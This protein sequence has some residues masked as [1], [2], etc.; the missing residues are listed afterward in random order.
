MALIMRNSKRFIHL[1]LISSCILLLMLRAAIAQVPITQTPVENDGREI[2]VKYCAAC[3]DRPEETKAPALEALQEMSARIITYALTEGKMQVH[4]TSM[5]AEEV[6]G[7]VGYL[8]AAKEVD[9]SWIAANSCP[10]GRLAADTGLPATVNG[11]GLGLRN[12]RRM[13]A[14]QAGLKKNDMAGLQLE[15]A[16]G[17]PQTASM[18]SQPV[19]IG[20]TMYQLVADNGQ[21]YALDI[22]GQPCVKW[23]YEHIVPLRTTIHAGKLKDGR[24]ALVFGDV[25]AHVQMLD[26]E[27]GDLIWRTSVR[28]SSVSNTTGMPVF[29][30]GRI[31]A[32]VSSGE[33]NMGAAPEYECCTSHGGVVA[34]D[35]ENGEVIWTYHTMGEPK[36]RGVNRIGTQLWGPSGAPIWTTPAI[37]EKRGVLYVGT[38]QNTS[39]PPT[40]TSD[41]VLAI[42]LED[43]SLRWKFQATQN[44]IFLT[45]CFFQPGGP[46]CP[47]DYSI[48]ADWD[49]GASM[50][51]AERADGSD[52]ILAG[53]K[54][55]E[56]WALDPDRN[57]ALLWHTDVGPGGIAGGI[58]WGMAYDG[59]RVFAAVNQVGVKG[60]DPDREPGLHAIDVNNGEILWS[61]LNHADCSGD[62][63]QRINSCDRNYGLSAAT[64][65][66][67][68]AV[69]QGGND[70]YVRIF[71]GD[72]GSMLFSYDTA[73][74]FQTLNGV[75]GHGGS[76]DC[77][78]TIAA[79]G[80]LFV[81]SGYGAGGAPGNVLLA[82]KPVQ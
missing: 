65:L 74:E 79:N 52:I 25:A 71:D 51:I 80:M 28:I 35:A 21:V 38:G 18:R 45:G 3:H 11:F 6:D 7:V 77:M 58:H 62:R 68:G 73:K 49:F 64:L 48:N 37:D 41:A 44:D 69:I 75:P 78:A 26:A 66:V 8:A 63:K 12:Y 32:P 34:L 23:V 30:K 33:L 46:N 22:E 55:G 70:G 19:I 4:S 54:S 24:T 5:S 39:E 57:G 14:D 47:P 60:E 53:Q 82:F 29:Y 10:A 27:K 61:F 59:Q 40:D 13:S 20:H 56:L 9:N 17:F 43:G 72:D 16:L 36:P 67:D 15:W 42:N 76:I 50:I 1:F 81:Q 31:F 2:Y